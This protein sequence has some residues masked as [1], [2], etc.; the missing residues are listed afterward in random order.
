MARAQLTRLCRPDILR[1]EELMGK[2]SQRSQAGAGH[3]DTVAPDDALSM[4]DTVAPDDALSMDD[5]A[6]T[7]RDLLASH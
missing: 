1:P 6:A 5:T 7:F 3:D 2:D 4:D